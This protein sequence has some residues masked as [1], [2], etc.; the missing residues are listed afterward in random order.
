[1]FDC[2]VY[3]RSGLRAEGVASRIPAC[4]QNVRSAHPQTRCRSWRCERASPPFLSSLNAPRFTWLPPPG[5]ERTHLRKLMALCRALHRHCTATKANT[6]GFPSHHVSIYRRN[7][8]VFRLILISVPKWRKGSM[9]DFVGR[10]GCLFV[11]FCFRE[12]VIRK[13]TIVLLKFQGRFV[14]SM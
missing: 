11:C 7:L 10:I 3:E 2:S 8:N 12:F 9:G 5:L 1:M 13:A 6:A 4:L 14:I